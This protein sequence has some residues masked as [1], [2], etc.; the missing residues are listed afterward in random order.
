[1]P[2]R[3][4]RRSQPRGDRAQ[5]R[6][7]S[8]RAP[9]GS[10]AELCA[11]V[12]ADGYGHGAVPVA[13]AALAGGA[14]WL[15]VATADEA[16]ELRAAG[17][18]APLLVMGAVSAEELAGGAGGS[19]PSWWPGSEQFVDEVAPRDAGRDAPVRVHVKLD[20]GMGRLGTRELSAKPARRRGD[21]GARR[22][23]SSR[24][25]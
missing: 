2:L 10:G 23:S 17:I 1:M 19:T 24:A 7:A 25:R 12:K 18:A 16:G 21:R 8:R 3:A 6:A 15:A 5:R 22:S 11:V 9:R 4:T 20:T 13:R 14:S